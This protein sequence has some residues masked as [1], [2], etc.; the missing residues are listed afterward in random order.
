MTE[1]IR[2]DKHLVQLIQCSRGEAQKYIEGGWVLVDGE[3]IDL[4]QFK[5]QEQ[6]VVLDSNAT[7][8]AVLPRTML[9]HVPVKFDTTKPTSALSLITPDTHWEN[10]NSGIKLLKRHFSRLLPTADIETGASGLMVFSQDG[11]IVR[12]LVEDAKTNEQEYIV[13]VKGS[14]S[15]ADLEKLNTKILRGRWELPPAKVSWQNETHL[16][17]ALKH[18]YAGQIKFM[19]ESVGL[20]IV[21]MK[22]IRIGRVSMGKIKV[23]EWRYLPEN[24][25][26]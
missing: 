26:F 3:I 23:G 10:D 20:T 2:L 4:P 17:F 13:E 5:I 24:V 12:K 22:R 15:V 21:T 19:C 1:S 14:L 6:K 9:L 11:S 7:L 16:R 25:W 8:T 18:V